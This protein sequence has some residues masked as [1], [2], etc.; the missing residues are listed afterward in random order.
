M[1]V[2]G[3]ERGTLSRVPKHMSTTVFFSCNFW[4][5]WPHLQLKM[6][7]WKCH[8]VLT[9]WDNYKKAYCVKKCAHLGFA[10]EYKYNM[11]ISA[12]VLKMR[13]VNWWHQQS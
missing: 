3:N 4:K 9:H 6:F 8:W 12:Q 7:F 2:P 10:A 5:A 1:R 11:T 13:I